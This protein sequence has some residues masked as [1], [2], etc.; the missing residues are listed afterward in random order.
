MSGATIANNGKLMQ[1]TIIKQITNGDGKVQTVWF[2]PSDFTVWIP[3]Q[4]TNSAGTVR[5]DWMDLTDN[6]DCKS[7]AHRELSDLTVRSQCEMGY[8]HRSENQ[9]L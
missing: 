6:I 5:Q 1:P 2:S 9:H 7:I 3:H 8:N 4:T